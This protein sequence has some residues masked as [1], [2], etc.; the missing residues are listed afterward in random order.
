MKIL[1]DFF[2]EPGKCAKCGNRCDADH[3]LCPACL[4]EAMKKK[5]EKVTIRDNSDDEMEDQ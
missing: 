5:A 4:A 2:G 3:E 1:D